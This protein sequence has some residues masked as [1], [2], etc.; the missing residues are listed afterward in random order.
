MAEDA[1][2]GEERQILEHILER[3]QETGSLYDSLTD[4]GLFPSYMLHM[5]EIGE[6]TGTLDEVMEALSNHYDREDAIG[7]SIKSAVTYPLIMASMMVAVI[8]VLLVKVMP[9]FNQVFVQLG[10]EMTGFSRMLMDL[11]NAINHCSDR[12]ACG[13]GASAPLLYPHQK[14]THFYPKPWISSCFYTSCL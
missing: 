14:R 2:E 9:I 13:C 8:I 4:T 5:V 7:K 10:T 1:P 3:M 12:A 11:G 6:E